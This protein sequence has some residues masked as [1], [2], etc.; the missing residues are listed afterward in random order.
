LHAFVLGIPIFDGWK[1][2]QQNHAAG[3][4]YQFASHATSD[5]I[6]KSVA[7]VAS[8][9]SFVVGT[10]EALPALSNQN[11]ENTATGEAGQ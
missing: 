1:L 10:Q 2:A 6:Q 9:E 4:Q 3:A 11:D 8:Q 5:L 7:E